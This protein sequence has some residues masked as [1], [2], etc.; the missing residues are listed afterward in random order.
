MNVRMTAA[1]GCHNIMVVKKEVSS[2]Q[3]R[4]G[5]NIDALLITAVGAG[6]QEFVCAYIIQ[7]NKCKHFS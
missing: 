3:R 6:G 7:H 1:K 4:L 2:S 5:S